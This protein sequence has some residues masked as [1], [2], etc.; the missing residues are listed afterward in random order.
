MN[1]PERLPAWLQDDDLVPGAGFSDLL[2]C[3]GP[4]QVAERLRALLDCTAAGIVLQDEQGRIVDCNPAAERLLGLRRDQMCGPTSIDPRWK[5]FDADERELPGDQH[6]AMRVLRTGHPV[7]D[8][9]MGVM[10]PD[11]DHRWLA[12]NS[13]PF[14]RTGSAP[15]VV[16]SFTDVTAR[17][18]LERSLQ[19]QWDSLRTTLEGT[20]TATWA[21]DVPGGGLTLDE[22]WAEIVG[23]RLD[24]LQPT[25]IETWTR[26]T[27]PEDLAA[28]N[29][30]LQRHF[31][32]EVDH[33]DIECR[34]RHR[35]GHWVWVRDR[36]RVARRAAD[37]TP[38]LMLGTHVD[39]TE[40]KAAEI[41]ARESHTMLAALFERAP[42]G[43]SL[44]DLLSGRAVDFN[45]AFCEMLGTSREQLLAQDLHQR[46]PADVLAVRQAH[47]AQARERGAYGPVESTMRQPSGRVVDVL[48]SGTRVHGSDGAP[49]LWSIVQD[50]TRNKAMER[51]LRAAAELDRL[52]GLPNRAT[53]LQRLSD[54]CARAD[55]DAGCRFAVMFL[56]F[57]RFKLVNDTLGHEAGD[58]L[59]IQVAERLRLL[60]PD[61]GDSFAARFGGDEFVLVAGD[62]ATAADAKV[63]AE[64]LL[65]DLALPYL[66]KGNEFQSSV[67]IGIALARG[68]SGGPHDLLRNADTAMYEAKRAG[69]RTFVVFDQVM[70]ERLMR[71]VSIEAGLRVAVKREEFSVVYQ[72]ILDLQTGEMTSVEALLRWR[73]PVLGLVSPA[74]FIPI[75]EESGHIIAIGE[76]VLREA[77]RQW[78]QW[79]LEDP[80][81]APA[82]MSVNI[83]RVQIAHGPQLI[84]AVSSALEAVGMP[85]AALQ[86]EIT[87]REVMKD[88]INARDLLLA[89]SSFGVKLAMD[90]FGTGS[91]SLGC[92]RDYPFHTIK[93][94]KSFVTDLGRDPHVLAVAHATVNVIENLGMVSVAEGIEDPAELA[95]LQAM[96]CRYG[97]GYL[98]ARPM[99]AD[100]VLG[101]MAPPM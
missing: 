26:L 54:W 33:Y 35:D 3:E 58:E 32:G 96:G 46:L 15:W 98:F 80:V 66:I 30:Q 40:R 5:A 43:I 81:R 8:V 23:Y 31:A 93:I 45:P 76:W 82:G 22:R 84:R 72:P 6:P 36:G 63:L 48:L 83:S 73:H 52:T 50:I 19:R 44:V 34:M 91:S 53:L 71:A 69:R 42:V 100:Q 4:A 68:G 39:I 79:Q 57:D 24:E 17:R 94:D 21:W 62:I 51:E 92:L 75:A 14:E 89:L 18:D 87:E 11:G 56:D 59:L 65:T 9:L 67:S 16:S 20:R 13:N 101:A 64:R 47:M 29:E 12:V 99:P 28:S 86:L 95:T 7:R 55:A 74:E 49:Y 88:P 78:A 27:H 1:A 70:H 61:G 90:D 38:E 60:W 25:T 2:H 37:G 97:Q 41:H 77:C 10:L 85:P